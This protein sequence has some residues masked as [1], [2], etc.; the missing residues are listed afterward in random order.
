MNRF[1]IRRIQEQIEGGDE[2]V[3]VAKLLERRVELPVVPVWNAGAKGVTIFVSTYSLLA[4][5]DTMRKKKGNPERHCLTYSATCSQYCL[6]SSFH[7]G[8]HTWCVSWARIFIGLI[9]EGGKCQHIQLA[10]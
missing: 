7:I 2:D 9:A 4:R 8:T 1:G 10:N 6:G 5:P 3:R